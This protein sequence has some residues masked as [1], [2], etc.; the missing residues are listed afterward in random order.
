MI[1]PVTNAYSHAY[2]L[3]PDGRTPQPENDSRRWSDSMQDLRARDAHAVAR[4]S[5]AAGLMISTVFMGTDLSSGDGPPQLWETALFE[6]AGE[7]RLGQFVEVLDR[8]SS[9]E[10]AAAG[11]AAEVAL[12]NR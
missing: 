1:D 11:H 8:Y 12:F 5:I 3:A 10:A 9:W 7:G 2:V 6:D 4:D